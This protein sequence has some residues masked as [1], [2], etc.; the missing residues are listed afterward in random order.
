[1]NAIEFEGVYSI[2][3]IAEGMLDLSVLSYVCSVICPPVYLNE[4]K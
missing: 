4:C 3:M 2:V 1:M